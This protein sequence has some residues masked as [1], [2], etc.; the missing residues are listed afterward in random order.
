MRGRLGDVRHFAEVVISEFPAL[1]VHYPILFSRQAET[2][3]FF[4]GAVM[5]FYPGENLFFPSPRGQHIYLPLSLQREPFFISGDNLAV[6]L[7]HP[8]VD[9]EDGEPLFD[10]DREPTAHL[11]S[12]QSAL[13]Q[14]KFGIEA[15]DTFI[16]SLL[17]LKLVEPIDISL[18]FDNGDRC[19][20]EGLYTVSNDRLQDLSDG[21]VLDLFRQG[22]LQLAYSMIGSLKQLSLL[23]RKR[24]ERLLEDG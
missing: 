17:E 1:A 22:Y 13:T 14:L 16:S 21:Q 10:E 2:G 7:E 5:G 6:D 19:R 11:K 8:L 24:N 18:S 3:R 20:L 4:A 12:V 15:T 9:R 23:T